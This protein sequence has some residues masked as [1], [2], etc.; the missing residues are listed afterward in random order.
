MLFGVKGAAVL[1]VDDEALGREM[2]ANF[3]ER[4]GHRPTGA[5]DAEKAA[6]ALAA[7]RFDL[8]LLDH[9]LPGITG[10]EALRRL[11][12]LTEAPIYL[13]SGF[14]GEELREDARLIGACGFL[15]K[16]LDLKAI[17]GILAALPEHA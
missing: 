8:V 16:P 12:K 6:A 14:T 7:G 17:E 15:S 11:L 1:I 9:V 13:M 3:L 4:L 10:L 2:L 5:G